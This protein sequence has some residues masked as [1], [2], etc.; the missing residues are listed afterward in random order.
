[1]T[2]PTR[3]TKNKGH[4][5]FHYSFQ[6]LREFIEKGKQY[7]DVGWLVISYNNGIITYKGFGTIENPCKS[8]IT[9]TMLHDSKYDGEFS[10]ENIMNPDKK[11]YEF[12]N[13]TTTEY[14]ILDLNGN[15]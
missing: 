3:Y 9:I 1:M 7:G 2:K 13:N 4:I 11:F 8:M 6:D 15:K 12:F 14:K 5:I 10:I